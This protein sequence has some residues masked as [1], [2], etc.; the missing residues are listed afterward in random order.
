M[1]RL[2]SFDD[3]LCRISLSWCCSK[4]FLLTCLPRRVPPKCARGDARAG[5][6][7]APSGELP[8]ERRLYRHRRHRSLSGN[9]QSEC[10]CA[11]SVSSSLDLKNKELVLLVLLCRSAHGPEKQKA[12]VLLGFAFSSSI[13]FSPLLC[14]FV[15]FLSEFLKRRSYNWNNSC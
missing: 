15:E 14:F 3:R 12:R 7:P 9:A 10:P 13:S 5:E 1:H 4:N 11:L 8:L 2:P 6:Q